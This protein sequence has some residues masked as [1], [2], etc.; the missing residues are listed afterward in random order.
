M[1]HY[2]NRTKQVISVAIAAILSITTLKLDKVEAN[3]ITAP[4]CRDVPSCVVTGTVVIG[5]V[6][7]YLI[8]NTVTGVVRRVPARQVPPAHRANQNNHEEI[9]EGLVSSE[10]ECTHKSISIW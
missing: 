3:P 8:K 1:Y 4:E 7:Y 6:V 9:F 10:E 5:G 2:T